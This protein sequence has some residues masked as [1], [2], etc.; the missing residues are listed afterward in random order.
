MNFTM[1]K[2]VPFVQTFVC[3]HPVY[4]WP[5]TFDL[6]HDPNIYEYANTGFKRRVEK[7][8]KDFTNMP[9][10]QTSNCNESIVYRS[11]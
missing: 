2:V 11:F 3:Q 6:K 7:A 5:K 4:Q 8:T 9:S 1:A 10:Q